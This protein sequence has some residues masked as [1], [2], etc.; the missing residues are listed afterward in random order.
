MKNHVAGIFSESPRLDLLKLW[1]C[2][3]FITTEWKKRGVFSGVEK[4]IFWTWA[5]KTFSQK[6]SLKSW[7]IFL[8]RCSRYNI[9]NPPTA[10]KTKFYQRNDI[11]QKSLKSWKKKQIFSFSVFK[12]YSLIE[13]WISNRYLSICHQNYDTA[14]LACP[15]TS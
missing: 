5:T 6:V 2:H 13:N 10:K 9:S 3:F 11:F 7:A 12:M 15:K 1:F 14:W 8:I 4:K